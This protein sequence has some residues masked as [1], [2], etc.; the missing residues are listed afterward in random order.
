MKLQI[1]TEMKYQMSIFILK[2]LLLHQL[3]LRN[4]CFQQNVLLSPLVDFLLIDYE[5]F[6]LLVS[7]K[8]MKIYEILIL[9]FPLSIP[10]HSFLIQE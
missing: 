9:S 1:L 10:H 8:Q 7:H 2:V 6:C 3:D 4:L 5:G